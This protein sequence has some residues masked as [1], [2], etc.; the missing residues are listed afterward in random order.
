[1]ALSGRSEFEGHHFFVAM[2][3]SGLLANQISEI[4][5]FNI[6]DRLDQ[7]KHNLIGRMLTHPDTGETLEKWLSAFSLPQDSVD[8]FSPAAQLAGHVS[9]DLPASASSRD[10]TPID[11]MLRRLEISRVTA[12]ARQIFETA[13]TLNQ[14]NPQQGEISSTRLFLA[15]LFIGAQ[16]SGHSPQ[17]SLSALVA[18][19]KDPRF[20]AFETIW[21][22]YPT[23]STARPASFNS[24]G[25]VARL[26]HLAWNSAENWFDHSQELSAEALLAAL[27]LQ[28][29]TKLEERLNQDDLPLP[30]LREALVATLRVFDLTWRQWA[31]ALDIPLSSVERFE[32]PPQAKSV[33]A[34][35]VA[36]KCCP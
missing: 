19:S 26:L 31:A 34:V 33:D 12:S 2:V 17:G 16:R 29:G 15:C 22:T 18:L 23:A 32:N 14:E 1:V 8:D 35:S 24:T 3:E 5:K 10:Q 28:P 11:D 27:L 30:R 9:Q 25:N 36:D 6:D 21:R 7:L 20:A 4:F 13:A